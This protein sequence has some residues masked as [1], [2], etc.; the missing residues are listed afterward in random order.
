MS[1][2]LPDMPPRLELVDD[3]FVPSPPPGSS[4]YG[5]PVP[6][7]VH[8]YTQWV[9]QQD[10]PGLRA[11]VAAAFEEAVKAV[12][13]PAGTAPEAQLMPEG[14]PEPATQETESAAAPVGSTP[15]SDGG[16]AA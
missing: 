1:G 8:A 14:T 10:D 15:P 12:P 11:R 13:E 7:P 4:L 5:E 16:E 9:L 2:I 6:I 3:D